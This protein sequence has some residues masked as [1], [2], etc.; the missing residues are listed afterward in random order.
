MQTQIQFSKNLFWDIDISDL[1]MEKHA[2]Y[3]LRISAFG[4]YA[5]EFLSQQLIK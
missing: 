1:D 2:T 3:M 4:E 5:L